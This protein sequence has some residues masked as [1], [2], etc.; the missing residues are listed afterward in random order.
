VA[1]DPVAPVRTFM[2]CG[3]QPGQPV[4]GLVQ[5]GPGPG[6]GGQPALGR[7]AAHDQHRL[8]GQVRVDR[9]GHLAEAEVDVGGEPAVELELPAQRRAAPLWG[10]EVE[11]PG[12]HRLFD[13]VGPVAQQDHHADVGLVYGRVRPR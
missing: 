3:H 11:K 7:H 4:Q 9:V 8:P 13:F 12:A 1:D 2:E 5:R 6:Q 10:A